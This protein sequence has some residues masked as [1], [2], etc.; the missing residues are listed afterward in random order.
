MKNLALALIT[1][2]TLASALAQAADQAPAAPARAER[3]PSKA[4][5][6][7]RE[8]LDA[9]LAE[10]SKV[11]VIDVRRPDEVSAIGGLPVYLSIQQ[12][13]LANSLDWIPKDRQIV[14]FSN[15]AGRAARAADLLA[16]RG[17]NVAGAA[18][19]QTYEKDGGTI[20][21]IPVPP[22]RPDQARAA[23]D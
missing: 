13:D 5:L 16:S 7:T 6:L 23:Q 19:A 22:P 18:G 17:F 12:K 11:L 15:H 10:P 20:L 21:H 14:T 8:E 9:L 3:T 4:H 2:S 1:A